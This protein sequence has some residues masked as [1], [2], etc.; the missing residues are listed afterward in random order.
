MDQP[1]AQASRHAGIVATL[2][3]DIAKGL[4]PVGSRF[5][6]EKELCDRFQVG[7]HTIREVLKLLTEQGLVGRRRK[8]GTTVLSKRPL[9]HFVHSLRDFRSLLDFARSTRLEIQHEGFV[10]IEKGSAHEFYVSPDR[11]WFRI[12]GVRFTRSDNQPLCWTEV[13][14][15]ERFTPDRSSLR[16]EESPVYEIVM[17]QYGLKLEYVEQKVT[18]TTIP[19]R[20]APLLAAEPSSAALLVERRYVAHNGETFEASHNLYPADRYSIY[21]IIRQRT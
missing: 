10:T 15:P 3:D 2:S 11:R 14:V 13:V 8:A 5:P 18:A 20:M 17:Q 4:Y 21:S 19:A 16:Q 1:T 9:S 6:P 7:R 12:A